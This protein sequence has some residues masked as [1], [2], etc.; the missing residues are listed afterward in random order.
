MFHFVT[1]GVYRFC[2]W[3][4]RLAY[5]NLLWIAFSLAGLVIFGLMPSTIAMYT[6]T[7]KWV[8]EDPDIPLFK[9][10]FEAYKKEF[11]K[12]NLFGLI[13]FGTSAL[14]YVNFRILALINAEVSIIT[15]I[16]LSLL[17]VFGVL[18]LLVF[19]VYVHY[20]IR[21]L[22][23]FKYALLI[24]LSRPL[25]SIA[26]IAGAI[27]VVY[28]ILLHVT[29]IIFFSGSLFSLIMTALAVKAFKSIEQSYEKRQAA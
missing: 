17:A 4:T 12:A 27:G 10:F 22:Q 13:L 16:F 25:N 26:M 19:P 18:L 15:M 28:L 11:K 24:G 2:E 14:F 6:V 5:L 9:T 20:D 7:R 3:V 1:N 29:L 8:T 21:M 23:T